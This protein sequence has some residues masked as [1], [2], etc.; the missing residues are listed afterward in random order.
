MTQGL[1]INDATSFKRCVQTT[2]RRFDF[3]DAASHKENVLGVPEL[4]LF[5]KYF[6]FNQYVVDVG[7]SI[8]FHALVYAF[9]SLGSHIIVE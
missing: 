2:L 4:C 8:L 9:R 5:N 6:I 7:F 3:N 1:I